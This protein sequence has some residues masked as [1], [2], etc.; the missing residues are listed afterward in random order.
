MSRAAALVTAIAVL[1]GL[2]AAGGV[3]LVADR[4]DDKQGRTPQAGRSPTD[5]RAPEAETPGVDGLPAIDRATRRFLAGY[6]PLIY[7]QPGASPAQLRSASPRLIAQLQADPGRVPP[8]QAALRP[9][10]ERV[11]VV[12]DGPYKAL[13]TAQI[14]DSASPAYPLIFHLEDT[15]SGWLVTRLGGT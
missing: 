15:Q 11:A 10:L 9:T 7:G 8:G 1:I 12:R 6:L 14:R 3:I 5:E 13:A 2:A 4:S